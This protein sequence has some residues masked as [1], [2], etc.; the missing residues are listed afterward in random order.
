MKIYFFLLIILTISKAVDIDFYL[1]ELKYREKHRTFTEA[2]PFFRFEFN[3]INL[4]EERTKFQGTK[5]GFTKN[6]QSVHLD[7]KIETFVKRIVNL[8]DHLK[9]LDLICYQGGLFLK[10]IK[11]ASQILRIGD[12]ITSDNHYSCEKYHNSTHS[13]DGPLYRRIESIAK[14]EEGIYHLVAK[15]VEFSEVYKRL[16]VKFYTFPNSK[17]NEMKRSD[18]TTANTYFAFNFDED[19]NR[20]LRSYSKSFW[21]GLASVG[22]SNCYSYINGYLYG[23]Y[24]I[25][26]PLFFFC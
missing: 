8:E 2:D 19:S 11:E 5:S 15:K 23:E 20:A 25:F 18:T 21:G 1:K 22:C 9:T 7:Y 10:S 6:G 17:K 13:E 3:S 14:I 12:I 26:F 16:K 24:V 4:Q